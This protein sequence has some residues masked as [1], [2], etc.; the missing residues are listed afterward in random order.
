MKEIQSA[1]RAAGFNVEL[2]GIFDGATGAALTAFQE[3]AGLRVTGIA[4][5]NTWLALFAGQ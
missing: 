4:D 5:T 2:T 3:Q 1:L